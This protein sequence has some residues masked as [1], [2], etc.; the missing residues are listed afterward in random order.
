MRELINIE[1]WKDFY[2]EEW[3]IKVKFW[4]WEIGRF[5]VTREDFENEKQTIIKR[6]II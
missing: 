2:D 1:L 4:K 5:K 3:R 6:V